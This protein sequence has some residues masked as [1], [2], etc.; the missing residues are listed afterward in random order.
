MKLKFSYKNLSYASF[1][2]FIF[3]VGCSAEPVG[4][5]DALIAILPSFPGIKKL[6]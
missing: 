2:A 5:G 4:Y 6:Q 3:F 1:Y